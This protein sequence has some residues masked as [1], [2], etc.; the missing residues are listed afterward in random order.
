MKIVL[1]APYNNLLETAVEVKKDLNVEFEVELGDL[2]EGAKIAVEWEKKGADIII[3]R[4]GT[5]KMIKEA[6]S[7]PVVEI[8]VSPYDILRQFQG[9]I[10]YSGLIGV[11]GYWNVIYGCEVIGEVLGLNLIKVVI[12]K[13]EEGPLQVAKAAEEGVG[14]FIGD[15]IGARSAAR[16]GLKSRLIT[17]GKEALANAV[18]EAFRLAEAIRAEKTKAEQIKTIVDFVHDG[19]IAVDKKGYISIYNKMAEKIFKKSAQNAVGQ[20]V[21]KVV[22]NTKLYEVIKSGKPQLGELQKISDIMIATN[23]VPII[24]DNEV[25]G[26]VATFQD[27]TLLQSTEQKIRRQMADRGLVADYKFDDLLFKSH[28]MEEVVKQAKQYAKL[29]STVLINGET[30]TGKELF[31]QSIHNESKRKFGPFVAVNCAA[32][33][34]N[35][36]ESELFGYA[37]GAFTGARKGGKIG[38]FELAHRGTIFLDEIGEMP[39]N[40]Q[41]R[42][43]RVIQDKRVMRIGDDKLIPV[44]VRIICA[45]NRNLLEMVREGRFREDLYYRIS[46]LTINLPAL[47]ERKEDIEILVQN[48]IRHFS[49]KNNKS[50]LGITP[51]AMKILKSL[52]YPGNVR[53]LEN[54]IERACALCEGQFITGENLRFYN[55]IK[56]NG[57][58][59]PKSVFEDSHDIKP[60]REMENEYIKN[61]LIHFNGNITKT[62]EKLGIDRT[63]LWRKLKN[64]RLHH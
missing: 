55:Q 53:E 26:A 50:I 37:E 49:L 23:R 48:F 8:K 33:P 42:L 39:L 51:E 22:P 21:E 63:T 12:E 1:I 9:L 27:V 5:Y 36:L 13:E 10:G 4:G 29:E 64:M 43:L 11:A 6:V 3:S 30:G 2:S 45:T 34:E 60:L 40:L 19:I 31:A 14:L 56:S 25:L 38:L 32:L 58:S 59:S 54:I 28:V 47:R 52:D 57:Q 44:D 61:V 7:V 17:S 62:A 35:L 46:V 41:S 15:T 24:V 16:L 18:N 20:K